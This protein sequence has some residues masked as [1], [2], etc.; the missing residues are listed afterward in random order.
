MR[1]T[2]VAVLVC[3]SA[4]A[5]DL[6]VGSASAPP[7]A[8]AT[9]FIEVPAGSDA[10]LN[11]PVIVVNGAK[12]GPVLALIAGAQGTEY[13]P[14]IALQKLA[15]SADPALISGS[16]V[17]VPLV[18][19][20]SF[21]QKVPLNPVDGKNMNRYYPGKPDGTETERAAWAIAK[22][23]VEKC[24]YLIDYHSGDLNGNI[25]RYSYWTD[26]GDASRDR[27]TRAMVLAFGLDHIVIRKPTPPGGPVTVSQHAR[28]LGKAAIIEYAGHSGT[29][30]AS[31]VNAL[32]EGTANV[33]RYLKML[34]GTA[35]PV[36]HPL[37]IGNLST[38]IARE[39][40]IFYPLVVPEAFVS[41]GMTIGY[42]TDY[43][44]AKIR[45]I[46][47][48]VS[49][50]VLYIGVSPSMKKGDVLGYIG[51]IAEEPR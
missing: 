24:D 30:E 31:D 26:T 27:I 40:G 6:T 11:I 5:G 28:D 22:Q 9:G 33:M 34:S 44:G 12:P 49:G 20:A 13:A 43:F 42:V 51:E 37:W 18:N 36:E 25:R 19:P 7:G 23:V 1:S 47:S 46:P 17:I 8:K 15:Q 39:D 16:L 29:T 4:Y 2:L 45:D 3:L 38:L 21:Q 35:K 32:V 48:P 14:I 41:Q 10:A 50:V